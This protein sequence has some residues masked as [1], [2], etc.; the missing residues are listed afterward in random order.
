VSLVHYNVN[1]GHKGEDK[2]N[3]K[4]K[5]VDKKEIEIF[6]NEVL[7]KI[8]DEKKVEILRIIQGFVLGI[9]KNIS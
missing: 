9:E 8:P 7:G 4:E 6:Y 1:K 5:G 2:M 3:E